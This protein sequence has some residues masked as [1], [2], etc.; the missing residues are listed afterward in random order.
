M[1]EGTNFIG[2]LSCVLP[3]TL[4]SAETVEQFV[5]CRRHPGPRSLSLSVGRR[6]RTGSTDWVSGRNRVPT[7][8]SLDW[9]GECERASV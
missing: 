7:V 3:C 4:T 9:R 5:R 1:V 2:N 8:L 6:Q